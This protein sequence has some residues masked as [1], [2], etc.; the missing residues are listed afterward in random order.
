[1]ME[2]SLFYSYE[3]P[4]D[5]MHQVAGILDFLSESL[6]GMAVRPDAALSSNSL[7]GLAA[8][9]LHLKMICME[10]AKSPAV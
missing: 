9:C 3:T 5:I 6:S 1:M 8:L 2:T 7:E 10:A 4:E